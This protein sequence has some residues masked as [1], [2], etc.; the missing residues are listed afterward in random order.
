MPHP[1]IIKRENI[2][3]CL[4]EHYTEC[5]IY[6]CALV[7]LKAYLKSLNNYNTADHLIR[8]FKFIDMGWCVFY[9]YEDLV[10]SIWDKLY[11]CI[12]HYREDKEILNEFINIRDQLFSS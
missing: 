2:C 5:K 6:I 1:P 7:G 9:R 10:H 4:D 11:E 8:M 12:V 3:D